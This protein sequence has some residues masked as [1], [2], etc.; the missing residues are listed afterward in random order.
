PPF[1]G[2]QKRFAFSGQWE[3]GYYNATIALLKLPDDVVDVK[4]LLEYGPPFPEGLE[5]GCVNR[6]VPPVWI[7]IVGQGGLY[8]VTVF[9]AERDRCGKVYGGYVF[10]PEEERKP[11]AAFVP[12]HP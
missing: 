12:V 8:P 7:S 3:Q 9:P 10:D 1:E 5:E 2:G 4:N 11:K 6:R